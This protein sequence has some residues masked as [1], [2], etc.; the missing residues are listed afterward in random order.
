MRVDGILLAAGAGTRMGKPKAL[1]VGDDGTPW[2]HAALRSLQDGGCDRVTVVL[3]AA[4]KEAGLLL[5]HTPSG[6]SRLV[7]AEDWAEGMG[8]S[9]RAG[10]ADADPDADAVVVSLVDLPDVNAEVVRRVVAAATGPAGLA[11]AAYD[12]EPGH[13]VL[14]GR[15][16]WDGVRET[17]TGDK[18]ARDYLAAHDV[19]LVECGDLATGRDVDTPPWVIE[20]PGPD[21]ADELARLHVLVW[22]QAYAGLMPADHLAGLDVEACPERWRRRLAGEV[23]GTTWVARDADGLVAFASSGPGRDEDRPVELE[24]YAINLLDRTH[25]TGLADALMERAVG[26]GPAYLWVL[27]GN[28]R[29]M[30]FYRRHGFVDEGAR[31]PEPDTGNLEV[32]MVRP[33]RGQRPR[34]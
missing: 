29:A 22:Q 30:A 9:L 31:K 16:H 12:G 23:P 6:R 13:P 20:E 19:T 1:V 17:A 32:R 4:A 21:D 18:G 10:L 34:Q 27:D 28:E 25:G 14:L 26:D 5:A 8:A 2:L 7:L 33:T 15:D 24:L 11:R 3:G